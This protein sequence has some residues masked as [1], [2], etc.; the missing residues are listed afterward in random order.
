VS[1][2]QELL[3]GHVDGRALVG[4]GLGANGGKLGLGLDELKALG[5]EVVRSL[6]LGTAGRRV[7][8]S[9]GGGGR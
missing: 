9:H 6:G 3:R 8:G 2:L 5:G 7:D 4:G 1:V